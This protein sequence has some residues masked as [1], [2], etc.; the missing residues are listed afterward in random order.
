MS[1]PLGGV[2]QMFARDD[3]HGPQH[4]LTL[5]SGL[6]MHQSHESLPGIVNNDTWHWR[7]VTQVGNFPKP[8]LSGAAVD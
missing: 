3:G 8:W 4:I 6:P 2:G 1:V 7:E 5:T